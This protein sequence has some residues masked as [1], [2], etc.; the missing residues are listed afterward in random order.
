MK[1]AVHP[2]GRI[3]MET[4]V[5]KALKVSGARRQKVPEHE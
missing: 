2:A 5:N 3:Q 1:P 4:T